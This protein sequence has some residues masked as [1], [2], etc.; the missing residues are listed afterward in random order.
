MR[1]RNVRS[2]DLSLSGLLGDF[3]LL[4]ILFVSFRL[5]ML[6]VYQPLVLDGVERGVTA[7]GDFGTYYQLGLLTTEGRLP[8]RDWWSEFPPIPAYMVTLFIQTDG[9]EPSYSVFATALGLAMLVFETGNLILVHKIGM[10]L[11]SVSIGQTLAWI[12]AMLLAPAVFIWWNFEPMVAFWLLLGLLLLIDNRDTSSAVAAAIGALTKFTPALMLGAVWRYRSAGK[13][14]RYSVIVGGGFSIVYGLLLVQNSAMTM[15]SLTAQFGKASYQTIWALI[16]GN[17]RT[18]NFGPIEDRYDPA[19]ASDLLGNPSV[20]PGWLRLAGA[21]GIGALVFVRT[22]RSDT[23]GLTAFVAITLL[24]FFLQAQGWSTQWLAQ[25]IPLLLL[26][27]PTRSTVL[28][29]VLLCAAAFAEYPMLFL[30][31]GDSGGEITGGLIA[32]FVILVAARTMILVGFCFALYQ[33]LRQEA[34][35]EPAA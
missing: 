24:I 23:R 13:A 20:I 17:Y 19:R 31:T 6:M 2:S 12:Y 8:F 22:R 1:S 14:L 11:H 15:P 27:L 26:A 34:V 29:L 21:A 5:M 25:I 7:G 4:L 28:G 33:K 30:R 35:M 9:Q 16:D 18:G 32:P 10:R 3:R